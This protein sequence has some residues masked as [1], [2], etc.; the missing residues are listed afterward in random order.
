MHTSGMHRLRL[1]IT[2]VLMSSDIVKDLSQEYYFKFNIKT[3]DQQAENSLFSVRAHSLGLELI[4]INCIL[5][6]IKAKLAKHEIQG[7]FLFL[8]SLRCAS[9]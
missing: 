8:H 6:V 7:F 5:I 9:S 3:G 2:E 1:Q 4:V